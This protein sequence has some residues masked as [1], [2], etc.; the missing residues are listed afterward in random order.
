M[1]GSPQQ[2]YLRAQTVDSERQSGTARS[3]YLSTLII[4]LSV[5][6]EGSWEAIVGVVCTVVVIVHLPSTG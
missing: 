2:C 6:V 5:Y 3:L 1:G 4:V